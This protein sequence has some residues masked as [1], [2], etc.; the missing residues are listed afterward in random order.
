ME[1]KQ[2]R[3]EYGDWNIY[4]SFYGDA[5]C[6][7]TDAVYEEDLFRVLLC[8]NYSAE[9]GYGLRICKEEGKQI[10]LLFKN[11]VRYTTLAYAYLGDYGI[12]LRPGQ[13]F[14]VALRKNGNV[15]SVEID[16]KELLRYEDNQVRPEHTVG[17]CG[18]VVYPIR[19]ST[20]RVENFSV[21]GEAVT[22]PEMTEAPK[23]IPYHYVMS[24]PEQEGALPACWM[25]HY[26]VDSFGM[27]NGR[28]TSLD[29]VY[30]ES[31]LYQFDNEPEFTVQFSAQTLR[32]DSEFGFLIRKAPQTAFVKVAYSAKQGN[33][34]VQDV[35]AL[36]DCYIQTFEGT[37]WKPEPGR[38]YTAQLKAHGDGL[39]L[40]ID[41]EHVLSAA[42]LRQTNYGKTGLFSQNA[43]W[44]IHGFEAVFASGVAPADG[45]VSSCVDDQ[46][47]QASMELEVLPDSTLVGITKEARY[48]STDGG[49]HFRKVS[50]EYA[51][52]D[53]KKYYQTILRVHDGSYLQ[54]LAYKGGQVQ[55]STDLKDWQTIGMLGDAWETEQI[56]QEEFIFHVGSMTEIPNPA[57]GWRLFM[58]ISI[59]TSDTQLP[60][61][62]GGAHDAF[63][64]YSDDGGKTWHRSAAVEAAFGNNGGYRVDWGESKVIDCDDGTLRLYC[65]RNCSRF[66]TALISRD[67]GLT[68]QEVTPVRQIQCAKSSYGTVKDPQ[69]PKVW[70][71]ACVNDVPLCRGHLQCR[72]RLSLY[73][74]HNGRDW[75]FLTDV[76]RFGLRFLDEPDM[77]NRPLYQIVDPAVNVDEKYVYVTWGASLYGARGSILV[78]S[79]ANPAGSGRVSHNEQRVHFARF[80]KAALTAQPWSAA[81]VADPLLLTADISG[82]MW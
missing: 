14:H 23:P 73:R 8:L 1:D 74:T 81:T 80:E 30:A 12:R 13:P 82:E 20:T 67:F 57:G 33:W 27:K 6:V 47:F 38:Q 78:H 5:T 76:E 49:I 56:E 25:R 53:V 28:L 29:S 51:G 37:P 54:V 61:Y 44:A 31:L 69:D 50:E 52:M 58:P 19:R 71:M 66:L 18:Y 55:R 46:L 65:S 68:W 60:V 15:L 16:D 7:Q 77:E 26:G 3:L 43:V 79:V 24:M 64:Y 42:G 35:P 36:Y 34:Y 39:H 48:K 72:T 40:Y 41:G 9:G 10:A 11:T 21:T 45:A 22:M 62:R 59:Q 4:Q 32:V 70:Y 63:C 17:K 2:W 75:E